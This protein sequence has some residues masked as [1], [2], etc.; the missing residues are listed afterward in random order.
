MAHRRVRPGLP[1]P[2]PQQVPPLPS[3][4]PPLD[5]QHVPPPPPPL[6]PPGPL[7]I[8]RL[9][10]AKFFRAALER[11]APAPGS[12]DDVRE[13]LSRRTAS[14]SGH[15]KWLLYNSPVPSLIQ[16]GPQCGLVALWMAG[17]LLNL[18]QSV[19]LERIMRVAL[20]RGYTAQGEMFSAADMAQL[21]EEVFQCR[22]ELLS[23]GLEGENRDR[24]LLHLTAGCPL[25]LPY[26][27][28]SNHEPCRRHGYKAHWAVV[29]GALLG[30]KGSALSPACQEDGEISGLFH[31]G[32]A[33]PL[34]ALEHVVEI[35]LL[36]KQGKSWR[37]QLW[38][39]QQVHESNAQLTDFSPK[40][41]GDGKVY[42]VPAGGVRAGLCGKTV[43]LHPSTTESAL[44]QSVK[45]P[46]AAG[47]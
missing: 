42:V 29:S 19:S 24:I 22:A 33:S 11:A 12:G 26:D 8:D 17:S 28:D 21:A 16:E 15:L 32:P 37:P 18:S 9:D 25:L 2:A 45:P 4:P 3:V 41:A 31:P 36:S 46:P 1:P 43:L 40:R 39:Y 27:E 30:L 35:Y 10:K 5:P 47:H 14:F 7:P 20:E 6:P 38:S 23:G 34:P 44:P 13:L